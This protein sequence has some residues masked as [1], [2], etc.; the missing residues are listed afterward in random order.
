MFR[1]IFAFGITPT[2]TK[3]VDPFNGI[4]LIRLAFADISPSNHK[5]IVSGTGV[6]S[7]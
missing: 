2:L 6:D 4:A 3:L 5:H 7:I 1:A